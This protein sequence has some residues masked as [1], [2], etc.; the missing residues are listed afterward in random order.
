MTLSLSTPPQHVCILR[1]SA[2][3]DVSHVLPTL[4][5]LQHYWPQTQISWIIGKSE[6]ELVK[7]IDGVEFITFDKS[8]GLSAYLKLRKQLAHRRF[9]IL[10]HMQLALRASAISC[11]VTAKIKLGFD[12]E[13]AK[14]LQWLFCNHR[15]KPASTRQHVVDSFLE[16]A[17]FFG[18]SPVMRW[19]LPVDSASMDSLRHKLVNDKPLLVINACAMAKSRSWRDWTAEG[20]AAVADY[21]ARKHGLRVVLSGGPSYRECEMAET[22]TAL[23]SEKPLNLVGNTSLGEL[24]ALLKLA[25]VVIAPD[26]GPAHIA[27]AVGTPVIGLYAATNPLRAAPYNSQQLVVNRYPLALEKFYQLS[28]GDAPW[29]TRVRNDQAMALISVDDVCAKLDAAL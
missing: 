5:T 10:L 23:C 15:I 7:H 19:D 20:Y 11:L 22:I 4:R 2:L 9:D 28:L 1:L 27:S 17:K 26:T 24:T 18:L 12:R 8:A 3:G 25:R 21:A 13:R 6:Y 16:F 29:G 14:D